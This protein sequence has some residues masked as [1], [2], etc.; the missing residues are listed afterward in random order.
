MDVD[1]VDYAEHSQLR[2]VDQY[3]RATMDEGDC[4]YVPFRWYVFKVLARE[5]SCLPSLFLLV[6]SYNLTQSARE[7]SLQ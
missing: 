6:N 5:T 1:R 3:V 4:L 2:N 7:I